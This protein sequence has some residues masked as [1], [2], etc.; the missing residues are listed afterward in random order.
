MHRSVGVFPSTCFYANFKF[1]NKTL[2][3]NLKNI[4]KKVFLLAEVEKSEHRREEN[5]M[6]CDGNRFYKLIMTYRPFYRRCHLKIC[7]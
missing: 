7:T 1:L 6:K 5:V 2:S 3:K 4:A